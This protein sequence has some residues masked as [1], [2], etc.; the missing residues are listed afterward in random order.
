MSDLMKLEEAAALLRRSPYTVRKLARLGEIPARKIGR[1]WT[2]SRSQLEALWHQDNREVHG[3]LMETPADYR[4]SLDWVM[5]P[6][7]IALNGDQ[8]NR[9]RIENDDAHDGFSWGEDVELMVAPGIWIRGTVE[10]DHSAKV[11]LN[12][13]E[14]P[15]WYFQSG[16]RTAFRCYL[17]PG[18]TVRRYPFPYWPQPEVPYEGQR[19]CQS[20]GKYLQYHSGKWAP[21]SE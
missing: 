16:Y 18:M 3:Q 5:G 14:H 15:G 8:P 4:A 1:D 12:G 19:W 10:L 9:L 21:E 11:I 6:L 13:E 2:F 17:S 20:W 7:A